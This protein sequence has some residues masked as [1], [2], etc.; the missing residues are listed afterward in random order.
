MT[1]AENL[2]DFYQRIAGTAAPQNRV[3]SRDTA[4]ECFT[5]IVETLLA[6]SR[7]Y[8]DR[9]ASGSSLV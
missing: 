9:T 3:D 4:S 7:L 8:F 5:R 1:V 2:G 6:S